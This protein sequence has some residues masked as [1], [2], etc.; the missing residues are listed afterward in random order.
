MLAILRE[1]IRA[2]T[3]DDDL[4]AVDRAA[5]F[6]GPV[7]RG[8]VLQRARSRDRARRTL[9]PSAAAARAENAGRTNRRSGLSLRSAPGAASISRPRG[10]DPRAERT[11]SSAC[12]RSR[13][14]A[15]R[16]RSSRVPSIGS[17][18]RHGVRAAFLPLGGA[19]DA[20]VSTDV[21]RACASSPVLLPECSL[22]KGRRDPARRA[23]R[24]RNAPARAR[25]GGTIR[26]AVPR[27]RRTIRRSRRSARTCSIRSSRSGVPATRRPD[28]GAIDALVD[29][30]IARRDAISRHLLD[31]SAGRP[32]GSRAQ[33]RRPRASF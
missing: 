15:M 3:Q 14:C 5:R 22:R 23:R 13:R 12:A 16:R 17:P 1:A 28:D 10:W 20:A 24:H 2:R 9:A 32:R 27:D 8:A 11:R 6:L 33:L 31:R 4:R 30:L 29:R 26:R 18:Q 7:G 21:I 25:S 19:G